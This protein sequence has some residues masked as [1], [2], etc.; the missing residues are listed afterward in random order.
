MVL[1]RMLKLL[2]QS[3]QDKLMWL[4]DPSEISEDNLNNS[5]RHFRNKKR[6]YVMDKINV[7]PTNSKKKNN[8]YLYRRINYFKWV[9]NLQ[10][11]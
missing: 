11:T 9:T 1:Q 7:L 2:D 8:R 6:E 5:S 3:E 10:V 4:Q